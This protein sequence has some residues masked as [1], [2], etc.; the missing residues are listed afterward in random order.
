LLT[1]AERFSVASNHFRLWFWG[2]RGGVPS[3]RARPTCALVGGVSSEPRPRAV[4][5]LRGRGDGTS[6]EGPRRPPPPTRTQPRAR[7]RAPP[8]L[9]RGWSEDALCGAAEARRCFH[10]CSGGEHVCNSSQESEDGHQIVPRV[11]PTG[12]LGRR[13]RAGRAGRV[14]VARRRLAVRGGPRAAGAWERGPGAAPSGPG[15]ARGPLPPRMALFAVGESAVL[16]LSCRSPPPGWQHKAD[17]RTVMVLTFLQICGL[18]ERRKK[19]NQFD[20]WFLVLPLRC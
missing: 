6:L 18:P 10:R 16:L 12:G 4:H 11:R 3:T 13:E 2:R 15:P 7:A 14:A 8:R 1:F 17:K 9:G 19:T 5:R 20:V